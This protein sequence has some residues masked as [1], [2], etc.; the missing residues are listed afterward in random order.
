MENGGM[1]GMPT[2][3]LLKVAFSHYV[4]TNYY[5][6]NNGTIDRQL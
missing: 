3:N 1:L 6:T 4:P 2:S 5:Q